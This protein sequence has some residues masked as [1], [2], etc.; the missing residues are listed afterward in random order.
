MSDTEGSIG[1]ETAD[2][3]RLTLLSFDRDDSQAYIFNQGFHEKGCGLIAHDVQKPEPVT[4]LTKYSSS[5]FLIC[6]RL[7]TNTVFSV[8]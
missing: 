2:E 7:A 1:K 6:A 5:P 3:S 4:T 8:V